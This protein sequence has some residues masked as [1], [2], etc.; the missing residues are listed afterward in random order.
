MEI[1][2]NE[3]ANHEDLLSFFKALADANR[4][5]IVGLLATQALTV[6][7]LA[8]MLELHPST[9]SHHLS[10]LSKVGL[11]SA[12]AEGYYSVYQLETKTLE[13]MARRLLAR[14]ELPAMAARE[15]DLDAYDR[16][17][18]DNYLDANGRIKAFPSQQKKFQVV[19]RYVLKAFKPGVRY[20]EKQVNEILAGYHR[21]TAQMRRSLIEYKMMRRE[22]GGGDYWVD[23]P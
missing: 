4:L 2:M 20:T 16:K 18:L 10:R 6:E 7:Q 5:K 13:D 14:D 9:V 1:N 21:D 12:K 11:V 3:Q 8:E 23:D 15:V 22:G 17:V 19:L